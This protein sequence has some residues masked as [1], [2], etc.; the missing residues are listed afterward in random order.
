M[1][2]YQNFGTKKIVVFVNSSE[3]VHEGT[4]PDNAKLDYDMLSVDN[5][6]GGADAWLDTVWVTATL[7]LGISGDHDRD[8]V[9]DGYEIHWFGNLTSYSGESGSVFRFI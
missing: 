1:T 5:T 8:G 9:D 4:F 2:V 6:S 7:P 3:L